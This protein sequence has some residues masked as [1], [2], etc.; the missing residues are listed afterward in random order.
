LTPLLGREREVAAVAGLLARDGVRLVTLTGPGGVGKT[1]LAIEIAGRR[2]DASPDGAVFVGLAP[3]ADPALVV[4]AIAQ[5]LGVREAEDR[6]LA[7]RVADALRLRRLVLVLDNCE[8]VLDAAPVVAELLAACPDLTVL[9]TSRVRLRLS[10]EQE[11]P[12]P[13]LALTDAAD[14]DA[15][16]HLHP[17]ALRL[18]AD[19]ARAVQPDF[20]LTPENAPVVAD[21]CRRL[22]GLP[23]AIE[24]A[25]ARIKVVPPPALLARLERRLP[26][27]T[28]GGRDMPARHRTMRDTIAWSYDL[29]LPDEQSLFRRRAVFVGGFD[30]AA[31]EAVAARDGSSGDEVFDGVAALVEQSLLRQEEG[32]G[33]DP[34]FGMLETVREFGLDRLVADGDEVAVRDRHAVWCLR[35]IE[36]AWPPR[37][38]TSRSGEALARLDAERDNVRAA[39]AWV[40]ARADADSALRLAGGLAEHWWLRGT[41]SEGRSWLDRAMALPGGGRRSGP[42]RSTARARWPCFRGTWTPGPNW[43][44]AASHWPKPTVISSTR[45]EPGSSS[46]KSGV[47]AGRRSGVTSMWRRRS[48]SRGAPGTPPGSGTSVFS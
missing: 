12:V 2:S 44:T 34:R 22:D 14:A 19:R 8:H 27:L 16:D 6:P 40:I 43:P 26:L 20:A 32:A 42:P 3:V 11:Y 5:A 48:T 4:P 35:V 9:A 30:L 39:L 36:T 17:A 15:A 46:R 31:A 21:I 25:A 33:G 24:L 23:L 13:P 10:A 38:T 37:A 29:L 1:R 18:F 7:Q 47:T 28:G 41:F 45:C